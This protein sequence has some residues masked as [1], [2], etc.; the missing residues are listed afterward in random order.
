MEKPK[1]EACRVA[2]ALTAVFLSATA[3]AE[4]FP[5]LSTTNAPTEPAYAPAAFPVERRMVVRAMGCS[6]RLADLRFKESVG[7]SIHDEIHTRRLERVQE[8]LRNPKVDVSAIPDLCG[9]SSLVDL[10]RVF[11]QRLGMTIGEYRRGE[12]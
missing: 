10:R 8:L 6:R 3:F 4:P 1:R 5:K 12:E 11:K 7:H 2:F 9:Y